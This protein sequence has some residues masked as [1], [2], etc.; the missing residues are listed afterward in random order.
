MLFRFF[1]LA[2]LVCVFFI[3]SCDNPEEN[4]K[5]EHIDAEGFQLLLGDSVVIDHPDNSITVS[6]TLL[7]L[8][9]GNE[10][11]DEKEFTVKFYDDHGNLFTPGEEHDDHGHSEE[12]I[13][14][15]LSIRFFDGSQKVNTSDVLGVELGH[16]HEDESSHNEGDE[17]KFHLVPQKTG[18]AKIIVFIMHGDHSDFESQPITIRVNQ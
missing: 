12:S 9:T 18:E 11:N 16:E 13:E 1:K 2:V 17:W 7:M 4:K 6:N 14:E 3:A 15:K 5:E 8:F 10:E